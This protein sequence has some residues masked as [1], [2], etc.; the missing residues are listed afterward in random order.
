MKRISLLLPLFL[1]GCISVFPDPPPASKRVVLTPALKM[2]RGGPK[3]PWQ[4]MIEKPLSNEI[5][6]STRLVVVRYD[7]Q[8]IKAMEYVA[9][10]EWNDRLPR[11]LQERLIAAFETSGRITGV[12]QAEES[13]RAPYTLQVDIRHF[14]VE[15]REKNQQARALV[16]VSAKMISSKTLK[17]EAQR[18]FTRHAPARAHTLKAFLE[19]FESASGLL[20]GDIVQWALNPKGAPPAHKSAPKIVP[21]K[22]LLKRKR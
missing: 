16:E 10:V 15:V 6:N 5:L 19:A 18:T 8:E 17:V 14:E 2:T 12:G 7:P 4:L 20:L 13:F 9:G 11:M 3:V 21:S 22:K 1:A